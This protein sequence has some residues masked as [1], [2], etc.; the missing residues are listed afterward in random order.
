P[1]VIN[2]VLSRTD[3]P[4]PTDSIE[5]FNPTGTNVHMGGWFLS[6]DFNTPKKFRIPDG[7][8]IPPGGFLVFTE[9]DF[10]AGGAGFALSSDGD[11]V[12]LFSAD[13]SMNL[14]GY[15][16]GFSFGAAEN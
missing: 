7:T 5:L 12:W 15:A 6:D 2:E 16:H 14:T 11:E 1:I 10:N 13:G 8:T 9:G 4:P 3:L